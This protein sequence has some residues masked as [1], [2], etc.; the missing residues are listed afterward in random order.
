VPG[1]VFLYVTASYQ[2]YCGVTLRPHA[3]GFGSLESL[4]LDMKDTIEMT[5]KGKGN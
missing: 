2:S 1:V 3:F 4:I 5:Y